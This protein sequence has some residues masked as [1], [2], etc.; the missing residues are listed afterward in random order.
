[1]SFKACIW[2][3]EDLWSGILFQHDAKLLLLSR[4][5][6]LCG[7]LDKVV[8]AGS[9]FIFQNKRTSK[10]LTFEITTSEVELT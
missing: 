7:T 9:S 8:P 4:L 1:M 6:A 3:H 10:L 5:D 2:W